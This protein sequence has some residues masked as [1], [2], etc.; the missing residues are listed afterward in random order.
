MPTGQVLYYF[1]VSPSTGPIFHSRFKWVQNVPGIRLRKG[2]KIEQN[3]LISV[4]KACRKEEQLQPLAFSSRRPGLALDRGPGSFVPSLQAQ[5]RPTF[6]PTSLAPSGE[7]SLTEVAVPA[8]LLESP[9]NSRR[10]NFSLVPASSGAEL[11]D[12][13]PAPVARERLP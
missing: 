3:K 6:S 9:L 7:F 8:S 11:Q 12:P 10:R 1:A 5:P 2:G 4:R 13:P